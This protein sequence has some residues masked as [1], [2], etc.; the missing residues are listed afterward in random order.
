MTVTWSDMTWFTEYIYAHVLNYL[1]FG[2]ISFSPVSRRRNIKLTFFHKV[3]VSQISF[4]AHSSIKSQR[5]CLR[6]GVRMQS[7]IA[8]KSIISEQREI[9]VTVPV[10]RV[11][12]WCQTQ[13]PYIVTLPPN[14][15]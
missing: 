12:V 14:M 7:D 4:D 3:N 8:K 5:M 10:C 11:I 9:T 13:L 6:Y 15:Q 1:S 2:G